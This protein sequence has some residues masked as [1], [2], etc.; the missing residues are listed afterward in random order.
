[1][2]TNAWVTLRNS[3]ALQW[4]DYY[5]WYI[6]DP[7]TRGPEPSL[8]NWDKA[9]VRKLVDIDFAFQAYKKATILNDD[10]RLLSVW[11]VTK[12]QLDSGYV[13]HG[14]AESGGDYAVV[15]YWTWNSS[16]DDYCPLMPDY[17]WRPAQVVKF[18]PDV[19]ADPGCTST[20]SATEVVDVN[21]LAGQPPRE[22]PLEA[23]I[24]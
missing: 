24:L 11:G 8:S 16:Y 2:Y 20:V 23:R 1:M 9:A 22:F 19:C 3:L 10:W 15:G 14:D 21:L 17:N 18:M 4:W 13:Q 6:A 12:Q 5:Q 7:D